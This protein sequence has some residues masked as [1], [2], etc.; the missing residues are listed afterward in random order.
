MPMRLRA[1]AV[2]LSWFS[3]A[4]L[5][6]APSSPLTAIVAGGP[7][8]DEMLV[9]PSMNCRFQCVASSIDPA[10]LS[11]AARCPVTAAVAAMNVPPAAAPPKMVV[12]AGPALPA[13]PSDTARSATALLAAAIL[14]PASSAAPPNAT[15]YVVASFMP[16]GSPLNAPISPLA[17]CA[18]LVSAGSSAS[19]RD[20]VALSNSA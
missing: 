12:N 2:M 16:S 18:A 9:R 1:H 5:S 11:M 15:M 7:D 17:A 8:V 4:K 10:R 6:N 3:P 13:A 19:P 14:G 20:A